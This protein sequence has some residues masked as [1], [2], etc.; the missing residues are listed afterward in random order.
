MANKKIS[1]LPQAS[2]IQ[3]LDYYPIVRN[4]VNY[5]V[6]YTTFI[7]GVSGIVGV[8]GASGVSGI[9]GATGATGVFQNMASGISEFLQGPTSVAL[10]NALTNETGTGSCVFSDSPTLLSPNI[11]TSLLPTTDDA[12]AIGS[13]SKRISDY[14][15]ASGH[16]TNYAAGDYTVTHSSKMLTLNA[17]ATNTIKV[18]QNST[19]TTYNLISLNG[20]A[21][22]TGHIGIVGGG[23]SD[24]TLYLDAGPA[25]DIYLRPNG[26]SLAVRVASHALVVQIR[27]GWEGSVNAAAIMKLK[28]TNSTGY[29]SIDVFDSSDVNTGSIGYA[30]SSASVSALTGKMY[31]AS[32]SKDIVITPNYNTAGVGMIVKST[33]NV[34]IGLASGSI[35][36]KLDIAT[37]AANDRGCNIAVTS[38]SGTVY[39][40]Y[41][42]ITGASTANYGGYYKASGATTNY[43]LF[44][45]AGSATAVPLVVKL[46]GSQS[47]DALQIQNSSASVLSRFDA[48]GRLVGQI[49]TQD[50]ATLLQNVRSSDSLDNIHLTGTGTTG[51]L[52]VGYSAGVIEVGN[53]SLA[54]NSNQNGSNPAVTLSTATW[55]TITL[56]TYS[57][58]ATIITGGSVVISS[59]ALATTATDGFLYI[60]SCAGT[61]TGVPTTY[62]GRVPVIYDT[63]NDKLYIYRG[64]WKSVTLA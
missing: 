43:S 20:N 46:A 1:Q 60:P 16:V 42:S 31:L 11:T 18:G 3:G 55:N 44:T 63:S 4:G 35:G 8:Q 45:E 27:Y 59:A 38:T 15:A 14:F 2:G 49:Y 47:A 54:I 9:Q 22:D 28:N 48:S 24:A 32:L 7:R 56:T 12:L 51:S 33:G 17:G 41:S 50:T 34:G 57:T 58:G 61:P 64:G 62:T 6:D 40:L 10:A 13:T 5:K 52:R 29:S 19:A 26:S 37:S 53:G 21:T 36:Y 23:G 39:G 25:G 30:N